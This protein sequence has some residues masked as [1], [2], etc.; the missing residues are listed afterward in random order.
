MRVCTVELFYRVFKFFKL[1]DTAGALDSYCDTWGF[2]HDIIKENPMKK[3][4]CVL[5]LSVSSQV[6]AVSQKDLK[7]NPKCL[8]KVKSAV[9]KKFGANDE[10]FSIRGT[11]LLYG[12]SKGGLHMSPVVLVQSSDENEPRDFVVITEVGG[13][14]H[15]QKSACKVVA[16]H[17]MA[18]GIVLD[19][20]SEEQSEAEAPAVD[21]GGPTAIAL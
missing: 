12:G 1:K 9:L 8:A 6:F 7:L 15:A 5:A 10:T 14:D 13:D 4:L 2:V 16:M 20:D 17:T 21:F 11:K 19:L 18:D 3:I